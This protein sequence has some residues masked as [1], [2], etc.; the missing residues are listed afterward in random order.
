PQRTLVRVL[1]T[2]ILNA[3]EAFSSSASARNWIIVTG[4]TAGDRVVVD[5][6]DNAGGVPPHLRP[7]LFTPFVSSKRTGLGLGL[8]ISRS[9]LREIGGDLTLVP[10]GQGEARFRCAL[11][12]GT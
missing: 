4:E 5:V 12:R 10:A 3:A 9:L 6:T 2:L 11:P 8:A 1:S 7:R